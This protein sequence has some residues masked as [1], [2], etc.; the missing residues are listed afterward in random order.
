MFVSKRRL[1]EL[2]NENAWLKQKVELLEGALKEEKNEEHETTPLCIGCV[3]CI[4]TGAG[5]FSNGIQYGGYEC[6]LNRTCKDFKSAE[7]SK[8]E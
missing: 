6:K 8:C 4:E 3:N 5:Y 2:R 7:E 1:E